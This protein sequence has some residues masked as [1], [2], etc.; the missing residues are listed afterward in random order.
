MTCEHGFGLSTLEVVLYRYVFTHGDAK[1]MAQRRQS[2][3]RFVL[4][5]LLQD[6]AETCVCVVFRMVGEDSPERLTAVGLGMYVC[7]FGV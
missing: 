6:V 5:E 3:N 1:V 7:M 2:W 4:H